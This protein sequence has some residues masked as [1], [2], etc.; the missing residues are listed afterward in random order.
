MFKILNKRTPEYLQDLFKPAC[1]YL[2][3]VVMDFLLSAT[4]N[5]DI[6]H[7]GTAG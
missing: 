3:N 4:N 5:N 1:C 6:Q 7:M 2:S